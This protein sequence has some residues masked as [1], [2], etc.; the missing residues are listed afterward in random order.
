[1]FRATRPAALAAAMM[2]VLELMLASSA[3]ATAAMPPASRATIEIDGDLI[4]LDVTLHTC[5]SR[6]VTGAI[7]VSVSLPKGVSGSAIGDD[8]G[9]R[10]QGYAFTFRERAD[11]TRNV[12]VRV[13]V[14]GSTSLCEIT[15]GYAY[16][17]GMA[18]PAMSGPGTTNVLMKLTLYI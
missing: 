4:D 8:G 10:K 17:D 5:R 12:G 13:V 6:A 11:T 18:G 1:M 7:R 9:F 16:Q 3:T 15:V 2:L 14:P